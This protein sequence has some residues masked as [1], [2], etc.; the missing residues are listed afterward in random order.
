[1]KH[2]G[3]CHEVL[4]DALQKRSSNLFKLVDLRLK[5]ETLD[6]AHTL[7]RMSI[8]DPA[9]AHIIGCVCRKRHDHVAA[10]HP[11][12]V[13]SALLCDGRQPL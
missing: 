1:M 9:D 5:A 2:I 6:K 8:G 4:K 7:L 10:E 12:F 3:F 11:R 13:R